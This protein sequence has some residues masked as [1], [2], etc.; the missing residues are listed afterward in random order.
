MVNVVWDE[1]RATRGPSRGTRLAGRASCLEE[2]FPGPLPTENSETATAAE[3]GSGSDSHIWFC[4]AGGREV[5]NQRT[6]EDSRA[7]RPGNCCGWARRCEGG[8]RGS[9]RTMLTLT[10]MPPPEIQA[11]PQNS[12]QQSSDASTCGGHGRWN[13]SQ[14]SHAALIVALLCVG[15]RYRNSLYRGP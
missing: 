6:P 9:G 3:A 7:D 2:P 10:S 14:F 13:H 5:E 11:T 15:N 8:A 4:T 12:I 1:A